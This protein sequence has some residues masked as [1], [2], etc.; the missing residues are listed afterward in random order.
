MKIPRRVRPLLER[1]GAIA[2]ARGVSAYAVGGCVRDWCRGIT[3]VKDL[4]VTVEG[5]GIALA[6]EVA[7]QLGGTVTAHAPFGTA[8]IRLPRGGGRL[9]V[10]SCRKET[11]KRP[12]AYPAVSAGTLEDDLFR[13]D[14]TVNAMA[15]AVNPGRFG[16]LI[17]PFHGA[18]DLRGRRLRVLHARSFLDDPS[19]ILRGIRFAQ[20][21]GL[22]WERHTRRAALDAL[23]QHAL[24]WLNAGR[25]R[26]EM[27]RFLDE[28]EPLAC[29]RQLRQLLDASHG[30]R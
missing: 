3:T 17:D 26:R 2:D 16:T 20:R 13:R 19:R 29:L 7:R 25:L 8:T 9:D 24:S 23:A 22:T 1:V 28:P 12:A 14:F 11:Y 27:E 5:D 15:L 10:A 4:D 6:R 30:G 18:Q 21:F